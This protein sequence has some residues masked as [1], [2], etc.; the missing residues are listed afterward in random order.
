MA[1]MFYQM[2]ISGDVFK[3]PYVEDPKTHYETMQECII[4]AKDK[5]D[6]MMKSSLS[7]PDLGILDIQIDCVVEG[8]NI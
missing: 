2:D 6:M 4:A 1:I 3:T 5:K 8:E 7:Y